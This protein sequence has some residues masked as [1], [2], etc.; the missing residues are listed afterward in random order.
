MDGKNSTAYQRLVAAAKAATVPEAVRAAMDA[1]VTADPVVGEI[2]RASWGDVVKLLLVLG[3]RQGS[4]RVAPVV[5]D[6]VDADQDSL[7]VDARCSELSVPLAIWVAL[8]CELSERVLERKI[9]HVT[10]NVR[11]PD[12]ERHLVAVNCARWGRTVTSVLDRAAE[13]RAALEDALETFHHARWISPSSGGLGKMIRESAVS[14]GDLV[15]LL[16]CDRAR[17]LAIIRGQQAVTAKEADRLAPA[18]GVGA[19]RILEANPMPP[20]ALVASLDR[21]RW[22]AQ[23]RR[24]AQQSGASEASAWSTAAFGTWSLAARQTGGT[25]E[26]PAWEER[27]NRFF[28]MSLGAD[29]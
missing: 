11:E 18:L 5:L 8:A 26:G 23:V 17:A 20:E 27:L 10:F 16:G 13:Q 22:R 1:P 15:A 14:L 29:T 4:A 21:P 9:A 24:L 7:I 3:Y 2:W 19:A 6:V 25:D 28:A 12:W